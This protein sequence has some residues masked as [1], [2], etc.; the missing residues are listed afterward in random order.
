MPHQALQDLQRYTG[1]Q[2]VHRIGMAERMWRDRDRERHTI[3]G[4]GDNRFPNPDPDR[5]VRHF[6]DPRFLCP[7]GSF[8][9]LFQRNFQCCDHRL[10]LADVPG[11]GERNQPVSLLSQ[12]AFFLPSWRLF[13]SVVSGSQAAQT[14]TEARAKNPPASAPV[15]FINARTGVPQCGQQHLAAQIRDVMEQG[16]HFRSQQI[17]RQFIM[18]HR[19]LAKCQSCRIINDNRKLW[20]LYRQNTLP[21]PWLQTGCV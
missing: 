8:I 6:P 16:T 7:A 12:L 1:I 10:Q 9:T 4:S 2:H 14:D 18:N 5:S 13:R 15:C 17:F 20:R 3:S 21:V 19:H 11:V